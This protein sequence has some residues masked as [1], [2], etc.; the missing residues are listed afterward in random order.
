[1][2]RMSPRKWCPVDFEVEQS[3]KG[4]GAT[5]GCQWGSRAK[6]NLVGPTGFGVEVPQTLMY[7]FSRIRTEIITIFQKA[8]TRFWWVRSG[9][10]GAVDLVALVWRR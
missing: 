5:V 4:L 2:R 1:M 3:G 9:P 10:F 6:L 7:V 8:F